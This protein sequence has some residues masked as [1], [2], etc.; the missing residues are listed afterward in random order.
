MKN[1]QEYDIIII[2]RT[3]EHNKNATSNCVRMI[4]ALLFTNQLDFTLQGVVIAVHCK[5]DILTWLNYQVFE[6]INGGCLD[7]GLT[8][9]TSI[10]KPCC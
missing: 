8:S 9:I 7:F 2:I 5:I 6:E 3:S 1:L 4:F 10:N